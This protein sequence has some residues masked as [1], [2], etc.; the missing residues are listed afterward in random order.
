MLTIAYKTILGSKGHHVVAVGNGQEALDK[1]KSFRPDII[2][3]DMLM[4]VMNGL[5]FMKE[6]STNDEYKTIKVVALTNLGSNDEK[7]VKE[8]IELGVHCHF[9]KT[10]MNPS[11]LLNVIEELSK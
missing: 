1:L 7:M 2:L 6:F 10:D 11:Q 8:T 5:E 3:L 4:P 9:L